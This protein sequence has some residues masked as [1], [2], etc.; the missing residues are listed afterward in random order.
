VARPEFAEDA[1]AR[2][3]QGHVPG[4]WI[5][6]SLELSLEEARAPR[7]VSVVIDRSPSLH[8]Y[9]SVPPLLVLNSSVVA[10]R[11]SRSP[12]PTRRRARVAPRM[13]LSNNPHPGFATKKRAFAAPFFIG[14][15]RE[16]TDQNPGGSFP[17]FR[18]ARRS[19]GV[20]A[21]H[22]DA[23]CARKLLLA[24]RADRLAFTRAPR[25]SGRLL[26]V[27]FSTQAPGG[28]PDVFA[29]VARHAQP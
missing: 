26:P 21:L 28:L 24:E 22:L 6:S 16:S 15:S 17:Y 23:K 1:A 29:R 10:Q 7:R 4:S 18:L 13:I 2:R 19:A 27:I 14:A 3:L 25:V 20:A 8:W 5:A 9:R 11:E 12:A